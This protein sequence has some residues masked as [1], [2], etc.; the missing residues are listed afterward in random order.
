MAVRSLSIR[1]KVVLASAF[2]VAVAMIL[3]ATANVLSAQRTVKALVASQT[4]GQIKSN[5]REIESWARDKTDILSSL[6]PVALSAQPESY[7]QQAQK[8]GRFM[9]TYVGRQDKRMVTNVPLNLP[10]DYDPT[11]RPWYADAAKAGKPILTAPYQDASSGTL[12]LSVAV[13]VQKDGRT[14]AVIGG[15]IGLDDIIAST[16]ALRPT[17]HSFAYLVAGDGKIIAHPDPQLSLKPATDVFPR[18]DAARLRDLA[19]HPG[20][21]GDTIKAGPAYWLS[22]SRI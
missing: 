5:V 3:L 9:Q 22:A 8:S 1:A 17:E 4:G 20:E 19:D 16:R 12:V 18:Y 2:T 10:K 13:P 7:L 14:E 21:L 6:A 11:T 15:D